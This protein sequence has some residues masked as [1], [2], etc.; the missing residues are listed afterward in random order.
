MLEAPR[1]SLSSP[2][3]TGLLRSSRTTEELLAHVQRLVEVESDVFAAEALLI[4][5]EAKIGSGPEW[6]KITSSSIFQGFAK[7]LRLFRAIG[8]ACCS[9]AHDWFAVFKDGPSSIHGCIDPQDK[10]VLMYRVRAQIP[11]KITNVM[12]VINETQLLPEWNTLVTKEPEVVGRRTALHLRMNYQMSM[13]S[14]MFKLDMLDEVTRF[15]DPEGGF[16]AEFASSVLPGDEHYKEPAP[17]HERV[18]TEIKSVWIPC[19]S[20]NTVLI[21]VGRLCLPFELSEWVVRTLGSFAGRFILGGLMKNSLRLTKPGN[22]WEHLLEEDKTGFYARLESCIGSSASKS[23]CTAVDTI[24]PFD[25]A[26]FFQNHQIKQVVPGKPALGLSLQRPTQLEDAALAATDKGAEMLEDEPELLTVAKKRQVMMQSAMAEIETLLDDAADVLAAGSR[27]SALERELGSVSPKWS[28]VTS[29]P[30][31]QRFQRL[32]NLHFEVGRF[33]FAQYDDWFALY[34][35]SA[36]SATIFGRFDKDDDFT[37]HYRVRVHIPAKLTDVMVVANESLLLREWN[38]LVMNPP[39]IV[40]RR[41]ALHFVLHYQ[42]S[43]L[44]GTYKVDLLDEIRRYIDV[45]AGSLVE[46]ICSV[47]KGHDSYREP[48]SGYRRLETELRNIWVACGSSDTV[49]IQ[50]GTVQL[51]FSRSQWALTSLGGIAGRFIVGG[52]VKSVTNC[53]EPGS[54]WEKPLQDDDTGLYAR[55]ERCVEARASAERIEA[56]NGV[57]PFEL[58]PSFHRYR[59]MHVSNGHESLPYPTTVAERG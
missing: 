11:T 41:K 46:H 28:E 34:K 57:G 25:M 21:Q 24:G 44:Q 56:A 15:L 18:E 47:P 12:A 29:S 54:P 17:G 49:L 5:F 59:P 33:C 9:Q 4:S 36:G 16:L 38:A 7:K 40:G 13:A 52:L 35:D 42:M 43:V 58:A 20:D 30:V 51:P 37:F 55:L 10:S 2:R 22:P 32:L 31:F 27:L 1:P 14:G 39:K 3:I 48:V 8:E 26:I 50:A 23:R 45:Q 19:G 6:S 53:K